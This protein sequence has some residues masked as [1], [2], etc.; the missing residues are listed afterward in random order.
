MHGLLTVPAY[1][2]K[3]QGLGL[4]PQH[5]HALLQAVLIQLKQLAV[6]ILST[7]LVVHQV[8]QLELKL[9]EH[10]PHT[11]LAYRVN[12]LDQEAGLQYRLILI[13]AAIPL[14]QKSMVMSLSIPHAARQDVQL[15]LRIIAHGDHGDHASKESKPELE[16][17]PP[18]RHV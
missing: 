9:M 6:Q 2:E 18:P 5:N 17:G 15:V 4:G 12:V 11:A 13:L 8:V 14:Q 10:G 3:E 16:H 1:K 7:L